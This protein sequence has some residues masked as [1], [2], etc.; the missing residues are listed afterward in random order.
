MKSVISGNPGPIKPIRL[1]I[2]AKLPLPGY[3]KTRL[4]PRLGA[5][6][7]S[8]LA[9]R[10]LRHTALKALEAGI[11][12]VELCVAP[13]GFAPWL[14]LGL[15]SEILLSEQGEGDLGERMAR[16]CKRVIGGGESVLLIG[17]DCPECD[18]MYLRRMALALT[19]EGVRAVIAPAYDGG[20][21]AIGLSHFDEAVFADVAWST[22]SVFSETLDRF[23]SLNWSFQA[24]EPLHDIDE[25]D[26]LRWLPKEW[27]QFW[28]DT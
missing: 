14:N 15:P 25:P 9:L 6:G 19:S 7:A 23:R 20:Y 5:Q 12:P 22:S 26:D 17:T 18:A 3:S 2:F 24:L 27:P 28:L 4:I 13:S 8:E 10:M 21:P 16:A 1:V 11:G